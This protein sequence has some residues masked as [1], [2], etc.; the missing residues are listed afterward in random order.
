MFQKLENKYNIMLDDTQ[1]S[2][3]SNLINFC[4]TKTSY[5]EVCVSGKAGS[6][7]TS[8]I[9]WLVELIGNNYSIVIC[10]PTHKAL[11]VLRDKIDSNLCEFSTLHNFL[12]LAPSFDILEFD[13]KN[14]QFDQ[15]YTKYKVYD[16]IIV[17]E[18]SMINNELYGLLS[19]L[20]IHSNCKII[21]VGDKAQL[22]P[23]KN[24]F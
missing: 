8:I 12:G 13:A 16:I 17:D 6:G 15:T 14:M 1:K 21:Y 22:A 19:S 9:K 24:I 10:A 3:L 11:Y 7:K 23:G 18:A 5:A 20:T 2:V 4:T